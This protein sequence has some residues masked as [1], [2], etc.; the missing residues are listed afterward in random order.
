MKDK[1]ID[2]EPAQGAVFHIEMSIPPFH[3]IIT[4]KT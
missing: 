1:E 4:D 2:R 3:K